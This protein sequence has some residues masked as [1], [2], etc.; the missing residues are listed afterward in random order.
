MRVCP[1]RFLFEVA[2]RQQIAIVIPGDDVEEVE[3][4][5]I[6]IQQSRAL[7]FVASQSSCISTRILNED[8]PFPFSSAANQ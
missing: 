2:H 8:R 6:W 4:V 7:S 3:V 1:W 5:D